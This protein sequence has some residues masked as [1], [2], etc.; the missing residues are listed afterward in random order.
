MLSEKEKFKWRVMFG[1][2]AGISCVVSLSVSLF[3]N[4]YVKG[5]YWAI[6]TVALVLI[7][8]CFETQD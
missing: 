7:L 2:L 8:R 3:R 6:L 5:T 1:I 4:D